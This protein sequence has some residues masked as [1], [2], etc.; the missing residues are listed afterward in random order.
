MSTHGRLPRG[1]VTVIAFGEWCDYCDCCCLIFF[2]SSVCIIADLSQGGRL[3]RSRSRRLP[4][5]KGLTTG[6]GGMGKGDGRQRGWTVVYLANNNSN[7]NNGTQPDRRQPDR[8]TTRTGGQ[9]IGQEW[10]MEAYALMPG[11]LSNLTLAA[12]HSV[13]APCHMSRHRHRPRCG[14]CS[15]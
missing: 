12:R 6:G 7:S 8:G 14:R 15:N 5:N 11:I 13:C 2:I 4:D 10:E 1:S 9:T 3:R